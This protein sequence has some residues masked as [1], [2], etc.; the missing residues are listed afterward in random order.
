V[1]AGG[2]E[3][4]LQDRD[5]KVFNTKVFNKEDTGGTG[6]PLLVASYYLTNNF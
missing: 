1:G 6:K 4:E 2:G 5:P 3:V